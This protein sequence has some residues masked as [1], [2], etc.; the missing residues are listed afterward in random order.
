MPRFCAELV[1][2]FP[3]NNNQGMAQ[4]ISA[5]YLSTDT[6]H[7]TQSW[8][9]GQE[10]GLCNWVRPSPNLSLLWGLPGLVYQHCSKEG[11]GRRDRDKARWC[12]CGPKG[13]VQRTSY[14]SSNCWTSYCWLWKKGEMHWT[15][16]KGLKHKFQVLTRP[17]IPP[18][19]SP[20]QPRWNVLNRWVWSTKG[21]P[22]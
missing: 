7:F 1:L 9:A 13:P 12:T 21:F 3:F 15:W 6:R 16:F 2:F 11:T 4:E 10:E 18:D 20:I 5:D 8:R 19:L 14:H 22:F 17:P